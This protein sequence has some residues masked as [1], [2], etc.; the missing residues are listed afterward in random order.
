MD[1][2]WFRFERNFLLG[3][4]RLMEYLTAVPDVKLET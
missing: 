3:A 2:L 4:S 1:T